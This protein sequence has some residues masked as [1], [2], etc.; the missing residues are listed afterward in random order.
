MSNARLP[1]I[2]TLLGNIVDYAGTFPPAQLPLE[3][4]LKTALTFRSRGHYPWLMARWV[5][6]LEHLNVLNG[7]YLYELGSSGWPV[8]LTVLGNGYEVPDVAGVLHQLEWDLRHIGRWSGRQQ[9]GNHSLTVVGYEAKMP[10]GFEGNG[11][12][13]ILDRMAQER[14]ICFTPY[15]ECPLDDGW[16]KNLERFCNLSA[17]WCEHQAEAP[18]IPGLKIRTG[19]KQLPKASDLASVIEVWAQYRLRFKATQGL[20]STI[21]HGS[22]FGFLNL[23]AALH[24]TTI[25]GTESFPQKQIEACL[26]DSDPKHFQFDENAF[27]WREFE[28]GIEQMEA[29]RRSHQATFGSCSIDEP[30]ESLFQFLQE[31][32]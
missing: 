24:L 26:I 14:G 32:K 13:L 9:G 25:L 4:S 30:D 5:A 17:D 22:D 19:G 16:K 10:M 6:T 11:L 31:K 28:V 7:K 12:A 21:T 15:F 29:S 1:A 3:E 20:H 2:Q 18:F 27:R 8:Q 23:F